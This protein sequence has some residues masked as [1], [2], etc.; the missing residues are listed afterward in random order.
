MAAADDEF[1]DDGWW[2]DWERPRPG[3]LGELVWRSAGLRCELVVGMMGLVLRGEVCL[4]DG[5]DPGTAVAAALRADP[6]LAVLV[7]VAAVGQAVHVQVPR[8]ARQVAWHW[9]L[10]GQGRQI[11]D[12]CGGDPLLLDLDTSSTPPRVYA[13]VVEHLAAHLAAGAA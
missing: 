4:P 7:P 1:S 13:A 3:Q 9:P 10:S 11:A 6:L 12:A 2:A 8:Q 5:A